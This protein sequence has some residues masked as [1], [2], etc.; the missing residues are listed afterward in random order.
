MDNLKDF[1]IRPRTILGLGFVVVLPVVI[2]F[3]AEF[4]ES[5][6]HPTV[7]EMRSLQGFQL[8]AFL[9]S[10]LGLLRWGAWAFMKGWF[11]AVPW[12]GVFGSLLG[13]LLGLLVGGLASTLG[14]W[15]GGIPGLVLYGFITGL[16][17]WAVVELAPKVEL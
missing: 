13:A 8:A 1:A 16:G 2:P 7:H 14:G 4:Q 15:I 17:M 11:G 12:L 5:V 6:L 3:I 9:L 10:A